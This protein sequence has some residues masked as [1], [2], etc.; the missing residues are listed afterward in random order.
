VG[1]KL[2]SLSFFNQ[3]TVWPDYSMKFLSGDVVWKEPTK[4]NWIVDEIASLRSRQSWSL[5]DIYGSNSFRYSPQNTIESESE[6]LKSKIYK[7]TPQDDSFVFETT[8]SKTVFVT[9]RHCITFQI[10]NCLSSHIDNI[11]QIVT[12]KVWIF[13]CSVHCDNG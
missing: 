13:S 9:F 5:L 7:S 2:L 8:M 6:I 1:K 3:V 4:A 10:T 12:F 11:K